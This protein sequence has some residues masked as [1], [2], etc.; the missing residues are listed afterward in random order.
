MA[1]I[2]NNV[3]KFPIQWDGDVVQVGKDQQ[4][5]NIPARIDVT[6]NACRP[7]TP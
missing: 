4:N 6:W 2:H 7:I 5:D 1:K 3:E